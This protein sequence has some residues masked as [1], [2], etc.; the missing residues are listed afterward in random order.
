MLLSKRP[1][2]FRYNVP[3][4]RAAIVRHLADAHA[5][6]MQALVAGLGVAAADTRAVADR[7]RV[8]ANGALADPRMTLFAGHH[9]AANQRNDSVQRFS[10]VGTFRFEHNATSL[11]GGK[12]RYAHQAL[13]VDLAS[14][15]RQRHIALV[16]RG[17]LSKSRGRRHIQ[18]RLVDD[19]EVASQH[20]E[21]QRSRQI[22]GRH[23][24]AED[25]C[26]LASSFT[27]RWSMLRAVVF[28]S[29][30]RQFI[31]LPGMRLNTRIRLSRF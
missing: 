15:A 10:L 21:V 28:V 25:V 1:A 13:R 9:A 19:F 2:G 24:H 6:K 11:T 7:P 12:H 23:K 5:S 22:V 8:P 29:W 30:L 20:G 17:E 26:C 14:A 16:L 27:D 4:A 3:D 31:A 18:A